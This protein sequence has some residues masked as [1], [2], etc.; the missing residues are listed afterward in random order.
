M[1]LV[2]KTKQE[3]LK[4]R[5]EQ[6]IEELSNNCNTFREEILDD[7]RIMNILSGATT[8]YPDYLTPENVKWLIEL[9]RNLYHTYKDEIELAESIEEVDEI[10]EG[11]VYP[12]EEYVLNQLKMEGIK[13]E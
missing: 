13:Y 10:F 9:F 4:K 7:K 12:T 3:L 6:K 5:K 2:G 1:K 8:G 11:I